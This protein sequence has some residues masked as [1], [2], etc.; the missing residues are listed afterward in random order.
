MIDAIRKGIERRKLERL[1][2]SYRAVEVQ[3]G[4]K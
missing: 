1:A 3:E 2:G 4:L